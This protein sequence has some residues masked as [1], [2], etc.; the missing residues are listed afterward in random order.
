MM[1]DT[2]VL[3]CLGMSIQQ[4]WSEWNM[5]IE[6]VIYEFEWVYASLGNDARFNCD[7]LYINFTMTYM[8]IWH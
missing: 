2:D 3:I 5:H 1:D 8:S 4:L 7:L 6:L